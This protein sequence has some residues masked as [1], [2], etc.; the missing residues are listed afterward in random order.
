MTE[1]EKKRVILELEQQV[2]GN[3]EESE[4]KSNKKKSNK[5]KE[6]VC[7][8]CG[9]AL[10]EGECADHPSYIRMHHSA[11]ARMRKPYEK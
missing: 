9:T 10:V 8:I 11:L 6:K 1:E 7:E 4:V 3:K 2:F 5:K